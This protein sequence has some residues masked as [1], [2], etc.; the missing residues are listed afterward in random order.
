MKKSNNTDIFQGNSIQKKFSYG[1]ISVVT[2]ILVFFSAV[3]IF[4]N[5]KSLEAELE[6]QLT[7]LSSL[8]AVTLPNALW[9]YNYEYI[10]DFANSISLYK[11]I[12]F[13]KVI[14]KGK[15]IA[16]KS[17]SKLLNKK[18]S[19]YYKSQDYLISVHP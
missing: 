14:G 19:F 11:D 9:Q 8:S 1:L 7:E 3:V 15:T 10:N 2:L 5:V 6:G 18:F 12:V 16:T 13:I 4:Y 17:R